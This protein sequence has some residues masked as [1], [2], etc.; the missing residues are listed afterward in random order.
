VTARRAVAPRRRLPTLVAALAVLAVLMLPGCS[1]LPDD[2][3]VVAGDRAV[4][5]L[6]DRTFDYNPP[7]PRPGAAP[8]EIVS[9]FLSAQQAVPVSTRVAQQY[10][11][12]EAASSW[13]PERRTIV[14]SSQRVVA[15]GT[16]VTVR[17]EGTSALDAGGRWRGAWSGD[18]RGALRIR[19]EREGQEWRIVDPPPALTIPRSHF[20]SRYEAFSLYFFDPTGSVLVP[21]PVYLPVGVQAATR[22]MAGLLQGPPR[23]SRDVERS[24]LPPGTD[25][26]VGVPVRA[27]G[28]AEVPLSQQVADLRP[29]DLSRALAQIA[30]TLRQLPEV[31][32][33]RV[34]VDGAPISMPGEDDDVLPAGAGQEYSPTLDWASSDVFGLRGRHVVRVSGVAESTMAVLPR[35]WVA[36]AGAARSLGVSIAADRVAVVSGDGRQVWV[37]TAREGAR[38]GPRRVWSGTDVLR[39]MWDRTDRLWLVDRT[40]SGSTIT[41]VSDDG[42]RRLDA[43]RLRDSQV[44]AAALSRDGTR[45]VVVEQRPGELARVLLHR[46][47]RDSLGRPV[48]LTRP[49]TLTTTS[50]LR[51]IRGVG[52]WSP[53]AVAVMTRP[54][55]F[56]TRVQLLPTDQSS[57]AVSASGRLD[58]LFEAGTTMAASPGGPKTLLVAAEAGTHEL[59]ADGRWTE[60]DLPEL[61]APTFVG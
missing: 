14:Y 1:M 22:L 37:V 9:G 26:G 21:E 5:P 57:V 7:G 38:V 13:R 32:G 40:P 41:V 59:G 29:G 47:I 53:T 55:D 44:Q 17:L 4:Q 30:F 61:R 51:S 6:N 24:Y 58:L 46:V 28:I 16:G 52:W 10:L 8:E 27:G 2:G 39:P 20:E 18:G 31:A 45:L 3:P 54:S 60:V 56:S 48:R 50:P 19:V 35:R 42:A 11:T 36:Q 15:D 34:L 49:R 33:I 25:L 23:G 12:E 43:G